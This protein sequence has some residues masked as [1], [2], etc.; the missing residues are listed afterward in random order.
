M[1]SRAH[2]NLLISRVLTA[3]NA[4]LVVKL[5]LICEL[6]E[7]NVFEMSGFCE[8]LEYVLALFCV[9]ISISDR[10]IYDMPVLII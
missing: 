6:T 4:L 2:V 8:K 5:G 9:L 7:A 3:L 10:F 1:S